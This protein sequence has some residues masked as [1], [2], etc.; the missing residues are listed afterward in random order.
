MRQHRAWHVFA[1]A[2]AAILASAGP[3]SAE[4]FIDLYGGASFFGDPDFTISTNNGA[5][6]ETERGEADTDVTFGGRFG[7]WFTELGLP[8]LGVAGDVSYFEPEYT[9]QGG[10]RL[11]TVK[12]RTVPMSPLVMLRLGF[13]QAPEY[14]AGQFQI[15]TG[16][17][18][19]FFW[20]EQT[21]RLGSGERVSADTVEVGVDFR[22]GLAWQFTPN[23]KV[24]TEYRFTYY[25]ISPESRV[26]GQRA[27]VEADFDAHHALVGVGYSFR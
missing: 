19:G 9:G 5:S 18:P 26:N 25:S 24:F 11:G 8:W 6:R 27:K 1:I 4:P 13:L 3:A 10:G 23:W 21:A 15:Y 7:Y 20:T 22:A 14:P 16:A 2:L 17:G 12:V